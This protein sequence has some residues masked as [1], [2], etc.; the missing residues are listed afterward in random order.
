MMC[1]G[2]SLTLALMQLSCCYQGG[3]SRGAWRLLRSSRY[4]LTQPDR[5]ATGASRDGLCKANINMTR[6]EAASPFSV[7]AQTT[8]SRLLLALLVASRS[9]ATPYA[10]L[11]C[12]LGFGLAQKLAV[13]LAQ[14]RLLLEACDKGLL[15]VLVRETREL[16]LLER[17][18]HHGV[19]CL[20]DAELVGHPDRWPAD[21]RYAFR[22]LHADGDGFVDDDRPAFLHVAD[23]ALVCGLVHA[24]EDIGMLDRGRADGRSGDDDG[25]VCASAALFG[26]VAREP[27]R[28]ASLKARCLG[29]AEPEREDALSAVSCELEPALGEL[30]VVH[31]RWNYVLLLE[32]LAAGRD[33]RDGLDGERLPGLVAEDAERE[34]L[35]HLVHAEC[36]RLVGGHLEVRR[37]GREDFEEGVAL[38]VAFDFEDLAD[39]LLGLHDALRV[40]DGD[41]SD[42]DGGL[43]LVEDL[44]DVERMARERGVASERSRCR[45]FAFEGRRGHLPASH[46]V[47]RVV[48]EYAAEV[49]SARGRLERVVEPDCAKVSVA[50][51]GD[52]D[53]VGARPG[54]ACRCGG[55]A[56]VRR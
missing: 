56:S 51:V 36:R 28:V 12:D 41:A 42:V 14:R 39:R 9:D 34:F 10:P 21:E 35:L 50:L 38:L 18:K 7:A 27:K 31:R 29:D 49:L 43:E 17:G 2:A 40:R 44:A 13:L 22:R 52:R 55:G 26:S 47:E 46:A 32:E 33:L 23:E 11:L 20:R 15:E 19:G 24:H 4:A 16:E 37:A 3:P 1:Y 30:R 48:D 25:A 53:G 5:F 54:R 8:R 6:L 45:R